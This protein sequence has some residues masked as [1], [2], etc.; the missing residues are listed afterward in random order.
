MKLIAACVAIALVVAAGAA[1]AAPGHSHRLSNAKL[2][3]KGW[4]KNVAPTKVKA[5]GLTR[6]L[7]RDRIT[8]NQYLIQRARSVFR[9][10]AVRKDFGTVAKPAS[11][12]ATMLLRDLV[13][14]YAT[15][16]PSQKKV[17]DRILARPTQGPNDPEHH[18]YQAG[19]VVKHACTS[20][21]CFHW[22][23]QSA[24]AIALGDGNGNGVPDYVDAA[25]GV[26]EQVRSTEVTTLQMKAPKADNSSPD[27][28][29]G[30]QTDVYFA[31]TGAEGAYGFC[32]S[33]DPNKARLGTDQY[34]F[35]DLSAYCVLDND[36]SV[37]QFPAPGANGFAA[38]QATA[39]HEYFHAI[40]FAY[41]VAEDD[42]LME[43]SAVWVE[44]IVFD[45]V[46]D[47]YQYL[48]IS[49]MGQPGIP[50]DYSSDA[51]TLEAQSKYGA[52]LFFRFLSDNVL[53]A[54]TGA[55]DVKY[56]SEIWL[57]ADSTRGSASDAYSLQAV[58]AVLA[59]RGVDFTST[60][61]LFGVAN[62]FPA[63][64]YEEGAAYDDIASPFYT[65]VRPSA[66]KPTRSLSGQLDHLTEAYG[67]FSPG[68]GVKPTQHVRIIIDGPL[69][70][71]GGAIHAVTIL[72]DGSASYNRV[73]LNEA[74]DA[75][76]KLPFGKGTVADIVLVVT[77]ASTA[78]N[79]FTGNVFSCQGTPTY[80]NQLFKLTGK[81]VR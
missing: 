64:F 79:C 73:T 4:S 69:P 8:K 13:V 28:G 57:R 63:S 16:S 41:D 6:A 45:T 42:W 52:F 39:A 3:A 7:H 33:D 60:Y 74:G 15:L 55:P 21:F 62:L 26:F 58:K 54:D 75:T 17:A 5:D 37:T 59:A 34:S 36:F 12:D 43:G 66:K 67:V 40:Q 81:I 47:Y 61:A 20:N 50:L 22:V 53:A 14:S 76:I 77:N 80:D 49:Q 72:T 65:R 25:N 51:D 31:D 32:T 78:F 44:D 11:R 30:P 56:M 38:L 10:H 35:Y 24:D 70:G 1:S 71:R 2:P 27:N 19:L 29:G 46:N 9:L 18:G 23:E 68:T 48:P